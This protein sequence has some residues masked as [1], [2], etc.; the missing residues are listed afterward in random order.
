MGRSP[1]PSH[2]SATRRLLRGL[3]RN[4]L[5]VSG[6]SLLLLVVAAALFAGVLTP[7]DPLTMTVTERMRPPSLQHLM[8][9][10]NFG[11]DIFSRVLHG[12][13]LSLEVGGAVMLVTVA[14]GVLFGL[15]AGY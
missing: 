15:V 13:R 9:T 4:R 2:D 1:T 7:Y 10:D 5:A 8:G 12:A 14:A 11:R 3:G 6:F